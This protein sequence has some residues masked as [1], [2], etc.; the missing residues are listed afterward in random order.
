MRKLRPG[1]CRAWG[2]YAALIERGVA[3]GVP[4]GS[5][6]FAALAWTFESDHHCDKVGVWTSPRYRKL[7][8]GRAVAAALVDQVALV[9]HKHPLWTAL[10]DN[11]GSVA[12]ARSLGFTTQVSETLLRWSPRSRL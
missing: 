4:G 10:P 12:L 8:L 9:R 1:R 5:S 7:G 11:A 6:G 3:F 2:D